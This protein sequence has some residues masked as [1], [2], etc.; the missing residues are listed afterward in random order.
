MRHVV[1]VWSSG[2][3]LGSSCRVVRTR[4]AAGS[5]GGNQALLVVHGFQKVAGLCFGIGQVV[6]FAEQAVII[7]EVDL[8][9]L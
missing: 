7:A 1:K 6:I 8:L 4:R 3:C 2:S 9:S 5:R